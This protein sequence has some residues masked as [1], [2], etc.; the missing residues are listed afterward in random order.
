MV[1][2]ANKQ[3]APGDKERFF[4]AADEGL[5]VLLAA[6]LSRSVSNVRSYKQREHTQVGERC[7]IYPAHSERWCSK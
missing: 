7:V 6:S 1:L 5:L 3:G 4:S 2:L